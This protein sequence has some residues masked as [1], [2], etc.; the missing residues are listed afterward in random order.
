MKISQVV[1]IAYTGINSLFR[2]HELG[3]KIP[4]VFGSRVFPTLDF[5]TEKIS[6]PGKA[7]EIRSSD[8]AEF[9]IAPAARVISPELL[10]CRVPFQKTFY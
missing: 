1:C 7:Y 5:D 10:Y 2:L 9:D 4:L 8:K 6:L 3:G